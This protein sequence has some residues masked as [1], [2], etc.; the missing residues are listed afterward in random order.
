MKLF[1]LV[2][3]RKRARRIGLLVRMKGSSVTRSINFIMMLAI[4]LL[5][6]SRGMRTIFVIIVVAPVRSMDGG[7]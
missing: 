6:P 1:L 7:R 2:Q 4:R 5:K 3:I